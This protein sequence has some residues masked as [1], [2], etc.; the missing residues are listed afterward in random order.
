[1][2]RAHY[3][4][5]S[6]MLKGVAPVI[7]RRPARQ[8]AADV[9]GSAP[10]NAR[11]STVTSVAQIRRAG[12][13]PKHRSDRLSGTS[14]PLESSMSFSELRGPRS[15]S[16]LRRARRSRQYARSGAIDAE[17]VALLRPPRH[18][19]SRQNL[20]VSPRRPAWRGFVRSASTA[21]SSFPDILFAFLCWTTAQ[22]MAGCAEYAQAMSLVPVIVDEAADGA[23]PS[24]PA[25]SADGTTDRALHSAPTLQIV[26]AG[27]LT[28]GEIE[29]RRGAP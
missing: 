5:I 20:R 17:R 12:M 2:V 14:S 9:M 15:P 22:F 27:E 19:L 4:S 26:R 6:E 11:R 23:E 8:I 25:Q 24:K 28:R 18:D 21:V 29:S 7:E 10:R 13:N 3:A 16:T 1:M